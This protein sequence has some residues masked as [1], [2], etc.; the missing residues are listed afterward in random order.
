[1]KQTVEDYNRRIAEILKRTNLSRIDEAY[2]EAM[3]DESGLSCDWFLDLI[4]DDW[5]DVRSYIY[6]LNE[7][8]ALLEGGGK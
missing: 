8:M 4:I 5:E 6:L 3:Y 1:M 2:G 7:K